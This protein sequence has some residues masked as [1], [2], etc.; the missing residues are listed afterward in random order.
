[1]V[2]QIGFKAPV[3]LPGGDFLAGDWM[4]V[5]VAEL[6]QD[7]HE[8]F[9]GGAYAFVFG[10]P[11]SPDAMPT[12]ATWLTR[13]DPYDFSTLRGATCIS[14]RLKELVETLEPDVHQFFPLELVDRSHKHIE[15]QWIWITCNR[16]DSVDCEHSTWVLLWGKLWTPHSD[17]NSDQLPLGFDRSLPS[18]LVFN[19]TQISSCH[20]WRDKFIRKGWLLCSDEA[21]D[22]IRAANM[23]GVNLIERE[24]V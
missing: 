17:L 3:R 1:M 12:R 4:A 13:E 22:A 21:A 18:K 2:W 7:I 11:L 24:A 23:V 9:Q 16:I 5:R 19:R 6:D 8:A 15:N 14:S 10:S 20:F